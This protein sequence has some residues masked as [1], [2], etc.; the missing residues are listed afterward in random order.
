MA[1]Q[2]VKKVEAVTP[3]APAPV[4]TKG[5]VADGK[6]TAPPPP[7]AAEKEKAAT[8]AEESKALAVVE[9]VFSEV[10]ME[11]AE[12]ETEP[13]PKKVSG[14]SIDRDVALA[15]LEKE[16]RLSFIKAWEDSEKTKAENKSQKNL[17]AVAAWENSKKAALE[18]KL[19]KK[20]HFGIHINKISCRQEKLEKQKAEYAEKMKN[21]IALIHKEAEEKKAIVE[22]KRGEE[23]LKA[24]ETAAKY[25]ATGQTPKKLLGCF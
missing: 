2:E 22:A 17:S 5:D 20:E 11:M 9:R 21:R 15:D 16:K 8:A 19:R 6:V 24:G 25:R 1:E 23:V 14:G 18:A 10:G 4:E 3:V 13:A 12:F 7:V